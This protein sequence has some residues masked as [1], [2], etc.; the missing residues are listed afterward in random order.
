MAIEERDNLLSP[1]ELKSLRL[2]LRFWLRR[3]YRSPLDY[4]IEMIG[5]VPTHQQ[6]TILRSFE[7]NR[8]VAVASGHGIGKSR[9]MGWLVNWWL[10]TRGKIAPITGAGGDQ[11]TVT[12]WKEIAGVNSSKWPFLSSRYTCMTEKLVSKED[13][14]CA[15]A[16]LRTARA[17]NNDAL[18]GFHDC[19]FFIDEGSGVR[20]EI[21]EVAAGAMGDPG[22]FGFMAGNPTKTSGYMYNVFHGKTFWKCLQFSS[23]DSLASVEYEY[24]YI[25]PMGELKMLK[26]KGRQTLEWVQN[27]RDTYGITSNVYRYRVLGQFAQM[28][29]DYLVPENLLKDVWNQRSSGQDKRFQRRMGVDP[30]WMGDDDTGVVIREGERILHA[31]SWHGFDLVESLNRIR[32]LFSEWKCDW[33]H[34]DA[35]GVGAGLYDMLNHSVYKDRI[36]YPVVKVMASASAPEDSEAPCKSMRDW[37][38]WKCRQ[39]F[40]TKHPY[41]V[42]DVSDDGFQQLKKE[43]CE[44]TYRI[45]N[46]RVVAESKDEL[47]KRGLKSPNIAD[48]LNLTFL[49]DYEL[50]NENR[51][52]TSAFRS[53]TSRKAPLNLNWKVM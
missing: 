4:V 32:I 30:A 47:K 23:E 19:M 45:S 24:P 33:I 43:I 27:M 29:A 36:G 28:G 7:Q 48:A 1:T 17:D 8:F 25:D 38:W 53:L 39:Y 31:E 16:V 9:L 18:Q 22:N 37:L 41:F 15:M 12:T 20:D 3:W 13:P 50:F 42:G 35:I 44:P 11:L 21:F 2:R 52:T 40:R 51:L 10:D 26:S 49:G 14:T 46:G 5:D 6:A 34:V